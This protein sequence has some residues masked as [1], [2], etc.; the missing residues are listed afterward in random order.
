MQ[1]GAIVN[2]EC[3]SSARKRSDARTC[4]EIEEQ[5]D[6]GRTHRITS[7]GEARD[8]STKHSMCSHLRHTGTRAGSRR[9]TW[10]CRKPWSGK[11][12]DREHDRGQPLDR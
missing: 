1:P 8:S 11:R 10:F 12:S 3:G 6:L 4:N 5:R 7:P 9:S 2:G